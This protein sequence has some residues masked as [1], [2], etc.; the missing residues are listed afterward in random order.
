MDKFYIAF[1][2][3]KYKP[4]VFNQPGPMRVD[5]TKAS[6]DDTEVPH[7]SRDDGSATVIFYE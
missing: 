6:S 7:E 3:I 1:F 5:W 4:V 2:F